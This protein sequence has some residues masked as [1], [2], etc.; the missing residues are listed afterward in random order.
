MT[1]DNKAPIHNANI[2]SKVPT[3]DKKVKY[4]EKP[5]QLQQDELK[6]E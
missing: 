5:K 4:I 6:N 1:N 2:N 3:T